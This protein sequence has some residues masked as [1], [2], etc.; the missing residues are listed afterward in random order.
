ME[1]FELSAKREEGRRGGQGRMLV[2]ERQDVQ[3]RLGVRCTSNRDP[4]GCRGGSITLLIRGGDGGGVDA[5]VDRVAADG[6]FL[7]LLA[8]CR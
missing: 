8:C 5:L 6:R 1:P 4:L 3:A 2:R 7:L